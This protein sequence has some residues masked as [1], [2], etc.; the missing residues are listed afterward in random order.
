MKD[1][2]GTK[3]TA[4]A[5]ARVMNREGLNPEE[6]LAYLRDGG[7]VSITQSSVNLDGVRAE[8]DKI[9]IDRDNSGAQVAHEGWEQGWVASGW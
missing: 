5:I 7:H 8:G 6:V 3:R 1:V 4:C 9:I 2:D